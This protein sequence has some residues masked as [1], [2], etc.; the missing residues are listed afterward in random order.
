M[1]R[2]DQPPTARAAELS[3]RRRWRRAVTAH[4][5]IRRIAATNCAAKFIYTASERTSQVSE[6]TRAEDDDN[7]RENNDQF[8]WTQARHMTITFT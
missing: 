7:N 3:V 5:R 6:T 8:H 4:S 1:C 2:L